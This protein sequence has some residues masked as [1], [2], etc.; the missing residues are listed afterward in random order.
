MT[1]RDVDRAIDRAV[2]SMMNVEPDAGTTRR[3]L[4]SLRHP[5]PVVFRWTWAAAAAA[6]I[7]LAVLLMRGIPLSPEPELVRTPAVPQ[8]T[9]VAR[10]PE[11]GDAPGTPSPQGVERR[12]GLPPER[13]A[14][15][16]EHPETIP[17]LSALDPLVVPVP[18]AAD[19]EPDAVD[20]A[21][22]PPIPD[23]HIEP[24]PLPPGS[25]D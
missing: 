8:P 9:A 7:A 1:E 3:V 15:S 22:L 18:T 23:L 14:P 2:R 6:A 17:A 24:V 13:P 25:R 10:A 20:V 12:T 4:A 19:I 16:V 5:E 21:P 11:P